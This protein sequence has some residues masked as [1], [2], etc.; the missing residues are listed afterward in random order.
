MP[1]RRHNDA[2]CALYLLVGAARMLRT[3]P[4]L[5]P[6]LFR[7]SP[8]ATQVIR[9]A[10]IYWQRPPCSTFRSTSV[11]LSLR[12]SHT[13]LLS[14]RLS[15]SHP[16]TPTSHTSIAAQPFRLLF[17]S[18]EPQWQVKTRKERQ[19]YN[20]WFRQI[21]WQELLPDPVPAVPLSLSLSSRLLRGTA[22]LVLFGGCL[23]VPVLV[24]TCV[25]QLLAF[26][27]SEVL[28]SQCVLLAAL[29]LYA[30]SALLLSRRY[31][32][33]PAQ[34][35][36]ARLSVPAG[37]V[38]G[39]LV[40]FGLSVL[41]P[42][43][44]SATREDPLILKLC[45]SAAQQPLLLFDLAVLGPLREELLF[46][47]FLFGRLCRL[48]GPMPAYA[49]SS[50]VFGL[51]HWSPDSVKVV[52]C[53]ASGLVLALSYRLTLSLWTPIVIHV[54]N[55]ALVALLT[56]GLS[57]LCSPSTVERSMRIIG[58]IEDSV[59][60]V[61]YAAK[62]VVGSG[63]DSGGWHWQ[64]GKHE[65]QAACN[66]LFTAL[67]RGGKGYLN[68][69]EL[70][71]FFSLDDSVLD[72]LSAAFTVIHDDCTAAA[73]SSS[74]SSSSLW[75]ASATLPLPSRSFFSSLSAAQESAI[76]S[77]YTT[78]TEPPLADHESTSAPS[79]PSILLTRLSRSL[80]SPSSPLATDCPS[81][82]RFHARLCSY[83]ELFVR[84]A[85]EQRSGVAH[86]N[87]LSRDE[88]LVQCERALVIHPAQMK[89]MVRQAALI[90]M[91][92]QKHPLAFIMPPQTVQRSSTSGSNR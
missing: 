37:V 14:Q 81:L 30:Q 84:V 21:S 56:T 64:S 39:L 86:S 52:E 32:L 20:L 11:F 33:P 59:D 34:P 69:E 80:N 82:Q 53:V 58:A 89:R 25:P 29:G 28:V 7:H 91:G 16:S 31:P 83:Y 15:A 35:S 62:T 57:P 51:M 6:S 79:A 66:A 61:T 76:T 77:L 36:F 63:E 23:F 26:V 74:S 70:G 73:A 90:A 55:N 50:S 22:E 75:S 27:R 92:A 4:T 12:H 1:P 68:A 13:P 67:D 18:T 8:I 71:F 2:T 54:V 47:A 46:R 65:A 44:G 87:R 43:L 5:H 19:A 85:S 45:F 10:A 72:A 17:S 42:T 88:F 38:L 60:S 49:V 9:P 41:L 78:L 48:L 40:C 3:F 24:L